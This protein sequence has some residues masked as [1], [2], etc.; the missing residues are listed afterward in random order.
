M[1]FKFLPSFK[2]LPNTHEWICRA[3]GWT[4]LSLDTAGE[5][6]YFLALLRHISMNDFVG[7]GGEQ[8][9]WQWYWLSSRK[10]IDYEMQWTDRN[11]AITDRNCLHMN[12][13]GFAS[14]HCDSRGNQTTTFC[15]KI[16]V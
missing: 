15:Q 9:G 10:R 14:F 4:T 6:E 3:A 16:G 12:Q 2:K 1:F 11:H 7:V 5:F 8:D 13:N